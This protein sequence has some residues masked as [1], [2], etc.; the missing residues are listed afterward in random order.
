MLKTFGRKTSHRFW[1]ILCSTLLAS[2]AWAQDVLFLPVFGSQPE[3]GFQFGLAGVWEQSA[4]PDALALNVFAL[5]STERQYRA[6]VQL[7]TRGWLARRQDRLQFEL[8]LRDFT[9][10]FYGYQANFQD[11]GLRYLEQTYGGSVRWWVPLNRRWEAAVGLRT[12][13]SS[14]RF[15]DPQSPLLEDVA[16]RDGGRLLGLSTVLQRD[17]RNTPDWPSAGHLVTLE[18]NAALTDANTWPLGVIVATTAYRALHPR[19]IWAGGLQLQAATANSPFLI[20][21]ELSGTQWMRG[22]RGGQ[23]RHYTTAAMQSELRTELSP[24]WAAVGFT[25]LGQVGADPQAWFDSA[26]KWGGG[27]GL[28]FS[29][30]RERRLNL[31]LDYGVVDGRSGMIISFGEAF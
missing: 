11:S 4:E 29:V 21:P 15:S 13:T 31:R 27:L 23:Y 9:D 22:L 30:S 18:L 7:Q 3:T 12:L 28:R 8:L 26:W 25:H 1:V 5:G 19:L 14:V 17:T 20:M 24:R 16:W 10:N 2:S 6:N